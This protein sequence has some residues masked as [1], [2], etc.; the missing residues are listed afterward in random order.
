MDVHATGS[1]DLSSRG[2]ILLLKCRVFVLPD[3]QGAAIGLFVGGNFTGST[4]N[5]VSDQSNMNSKMLR[6]GFF[7]EEF[8]LSKH[9]RL[10]QKM[11]N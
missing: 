11:H 6:Y 10:P 9:K 3:W 5:V 2:R 4:S 7:V 8:H 1:Q